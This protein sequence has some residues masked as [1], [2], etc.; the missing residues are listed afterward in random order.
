[1]PRVRDPERFGHLVA[2]AIEV[3]IER[4]YTQTQISHI[5]EAMG[6]AK[7]TIYLYVESKEAL[8]DL[9]VRGAHG[10]LQPQPVLP[11]P[12][13]DPDATLR[14]VR[15]ALSTDMRLPKLQAALE[16]AHT[17]DVRSELA[18][19]AR[20]LYQLMHE[21]RVALKLVDRSATEYPELAA[22]FFDTARQAIPQ[23]LFEYLESRVPKD[24]ELP[25]RA[26][27]RG[28]VEVIA[29]WAIHRHWDP[30]PTRVS[31]D[32]SERAAVLFA[33]GALGP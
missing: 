21:H 20:E 2:T 17:E 12:T 29:L 26:L 1:M 33:L 22:I 13:P 4:G 28:L 10:S 18:E 31:E 19:I 32:D 9:A 3:F 7:G 15:D 27:A 8:F 25:L 5:A 24:R 16:R 30:A 14:Y 23:L 6:V 11:V